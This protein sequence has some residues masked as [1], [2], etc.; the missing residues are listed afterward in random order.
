MN[1]SSDLNRQVVK[2][3]HAT[4]SVPQVNLEIPPES[5]AGS[6]STIE[7][8]I[9]RVIDGLEQDQKIRQ[10]TDP[11]SFEK[12]KDFVTRLRDLKDS[13]L[14]FDFVLDDPSGNSFVENPSAPNK[15]SNRIFMQGKEFAYKQKEK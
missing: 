1:E 8:V 9:Q 2:G 12:V 11:D 13:D 5:Q 14:G 3:E 15:E 10:L 4:I 6:I 7:G